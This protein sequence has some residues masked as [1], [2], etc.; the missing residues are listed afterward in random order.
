MGDKS[1]D[2]NFFRVYIHGIRRHMKTAQDFLRAYNKLC[3][4]MGFQLGATP[5]YRLRDDGTYSLIIKIVVQ[6]VKRE[7]GN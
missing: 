1:F 4:V 7:T 6:E 2:N 5:E 3:N